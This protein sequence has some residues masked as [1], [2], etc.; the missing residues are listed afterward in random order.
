[1]E[2]VHIHQIAIIAF[3][4]VIGF[5]VAFFAWG[6]VRNDTPVVTVASISKDYVVDQDLVPDFP[7]IKLPPISPISPK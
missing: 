5:T 1:M 7:S 6:A 2:K 4:A 3:F